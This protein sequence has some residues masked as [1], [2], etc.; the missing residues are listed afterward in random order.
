MG[1]RKHLPND[2]WGN[3]TFEKTLPI[4]LNAEILLKTKTLSPGSQLPAEHTNTHTHT[5][6]ITHTYYTNNALTPQAN[7]YTYM[8]HTLITK[9]YTINTH[10]YTTHIYIIHIYPT[11]KPHIHHI[12]THTLQDTHATEITHTH[13]TH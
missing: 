8:T 11:H 7:I 3:E 2:F 12:Y 5:I 1:L 6:F 4:D 13:S 9:K 10:T